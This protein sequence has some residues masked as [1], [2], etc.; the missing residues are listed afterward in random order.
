MINKIEAITLSE[1][2]LKGNAITIEYGLHDSP[3]GKCLVC[4]SNQ[5]ICSIAFTCND[6]VNAT[7]KEIQGFWP[8]SKFTK[9]NNITKPYVEKLFFSKH[10]KKNRFDVLLKGTDFQIKVWKAL[11]SIPFAKLSNYESLAKEIGDVRATRAVAS[12]I[13]RNWIA[14]LIP[15]HRVINKSGKIGKYRWGDKLKKAMHEWEQNRV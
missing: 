7:L 8:R 9:N 11:I 5:R 13:A 14:F 4:V 6:E 15:C 2:K 12:A 1:Y 10:P 3:F